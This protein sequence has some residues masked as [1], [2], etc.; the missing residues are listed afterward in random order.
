MGEMGGSRDSRSRKQRPDHNVLVKS[1]YA[2]SQETL[3][4]GSGRLGAI[5]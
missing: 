3:S 1:K 4:M 5:Q 2:T